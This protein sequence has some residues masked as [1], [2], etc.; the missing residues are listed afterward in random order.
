MK[1]IFPRMETTNFHKAYDGGCKY[2]QQFAESL[3]K[4]G[5]EVE[6]VTTR[7]RDNPNLITEKYRGVKHTFLPP[8]YTGKKLIPFNIFYK[9]MF[10]YHLNKYLKSINFD[11]LHSCEM[12][13]LFYLKNK[14]RNPTIFQ[15]WA[16]EPFYGDEC[17]SHKGLKRLYVK[18]FLQK[19]WLYCI[20]NYNNVFSC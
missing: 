8:K 16:L 17:N 14:K 18:L 3:I 7:I 20:N 6:I 2:I 9:I 13:S 19:P 10:S 4:E 11:I 15:S 1:I 5:H 12:F